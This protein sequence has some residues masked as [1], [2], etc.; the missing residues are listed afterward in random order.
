MKKRFLRIF[1]LI[2]CVALFMTGCATVSNV[3]IN[4][5]DAYFENLQYS[6]G[7][8]LVVGDYVYFG[9]GYTSSSDSGFDYNSATSTGYLSRLN[10]TSNL[11][12]GSDVK[13]EDKIYTTPNQTEKVSDKKLIGYQNQDMYALGDYIYF[14]SANTHKTTS[15]ENDY[16][17]VSLFRVK[18]N[19]NGLKELVKNTAFKQGTGSTITVQKGSD[20]NY[21]YIIVEPAD[22]NTF[23]IKTL[24]IGN[25]IGKINT[26]AEKVTSYAIADEKSTQRNIIYSVNSNQAQTTS[27][28]KAVDFA[29]GTVT[30]LDNG[31]TGSTVSFLGRA[32]DI[33]FYSYT[34]KAVQEVYYKNILN[35]IGYFNPTYSSVFYNAKTI[36]EIKSAGDGYIFK[37]EGGALLY[38]E[39]NSSSSLL[40][41]SED[42][43]DILFVENDYVYT[44]NTSSIK[45]I[46]TVDKEIETIL[47]LE[48]QTIISGQCGYDGQ[49][50]YYY[51]QKPASE[52]EDAV[53]DTNNYMFRTDKFGNYQM[54]GKSR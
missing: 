15:M 7:Q 12:F 37:T 25:K 35:G 4:G 10:L 17:M 14:S 5:K 1:A 26:I 54:V 28:V 24:Q 16:T 32:G 9:N 52:D 8:A 39:L 31:V 48:G 3:K 29:T 11:T 20:N 6:Q 45:R 22:D 50:I 51:S 2:F 38:K 18:F 43:T 21:Y 53:T 40:M 41:T 34:Y 13:E 44:S 27:A 47:T 46:N 19:G 36:S 23:T 30:D 42:Y 49:Y 33:V